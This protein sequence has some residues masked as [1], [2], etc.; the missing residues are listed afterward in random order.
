MNNTE[1]IQGDNLGV[2]FLHLRVN[3]LIKDSSIKSDVV[4]LLYAIALKYTS[5]KKPE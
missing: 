2:Y 5:H 3:I 4:T 1:K